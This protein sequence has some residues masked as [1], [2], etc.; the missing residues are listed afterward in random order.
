MHRNALH[1]YVP[2]ATLDAS[3]EATRV[4]SI[5]PARN[6]SRSDNTLTKID[7]QFAE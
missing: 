7:P 6:G 3:A 2:L 4:G 5:F 1:F